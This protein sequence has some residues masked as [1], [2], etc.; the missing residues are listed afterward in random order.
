[1][2]RERQGTRRFL[3]QKRYSVRKDQGAALVEF[4]LVAPVF[5]ALV[6]GGLV[7]LWSIYRS[8]ALN[9]IAF[10]AVRS[11]IILAQLA[12]SNSP[13]TFILNQLATESAKWGV[14]V[15]MGR[16]N[17]CPLE[18]PL[19]GGGSVGAESAFSMNITATTNSLES[20]FNITPR[21][22]AAGINAAP[23]GVSTMP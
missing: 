8:V 15:D 9:Y 20:A 17:F 2:K 7:F 23:I 14:N 21:G 6:I 12:K 5:I 1:M 13:E 19:C 16:V 4:A 10:R 22:F 18:A 11:G 3:K